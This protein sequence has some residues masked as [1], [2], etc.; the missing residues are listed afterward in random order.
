MEAK[1]FSEGD[2]ILAKRGGVALLQT[3]LESVTGLRLDSDVSPYY[4]SNS[5]RPGKLIQIRLVQK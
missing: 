4:L 3:E 1:P 5:D 2:V